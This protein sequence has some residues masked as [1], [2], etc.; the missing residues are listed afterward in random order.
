MKT[1]ITYIAALLMGAATALLF[2][3]SST[4]LGAMGAISSFLVN[5][6]VCIAIPV[7]FITFASGTASLGKDRKGGKA[8]AASVLWAIATT[9]ILTLSA[10]AISK[11]MPVSFPVTSTAGNPQEI[12]STHVSYLITNGYSSLYPR[13]PFLTLASSYYFILPVVIISWILGLSLRPSSDIIRP[14]Y[15]VMNSF[16]EV[17]YRISRT[18]SVYGFFLVYASSAYSFASLY[19]EKTI[20]A[21]PRFALLLIGGGIMAAV[22]LI[23]LI[24]A[25]FTGFRK[26]PYRALYR[27]IPAAI[28]GLATGN[29]ISIL[30]IEEGIARQN[31]G[32]QKRIA[33]V[34]VPLLSMIGKGGS[35]FVSTMT[36]IALFQATTGTEASLSVMLMAGGMA[37]LISFISSLSTGME[38]T[39]ITVLTLQALGIN[40]YGA[41]N[42]IIAFMPLLGGVG[43]ML[44]GLISTIGSSI[45]AAFIET[46][47]DIPY[48]DTL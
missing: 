13:N 45:A 6:G 3:D 41:E 18:V 8:A 1:W 12:L 24:Y 34:S 31:L 46:D 21:S 15:T 32:V 7:L 44:D 11:A 4:A 2:G 19:Q 33:S 20:I 9:V 25:L 28:A 30:A 42:A 26:N 27:S 38:T 43:I 36:L 23:P 17:M 10:V 35:A 47:I 5:L 40:L 22:V 48:K 39:L 37:A 14:A 29:G 16:S